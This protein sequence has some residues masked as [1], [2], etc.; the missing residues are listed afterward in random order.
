[1]D[2]QFY[3]LS[4]LCLVAG[5][6]L[7]SVARVHAAVTVAPIAQD[8]SA[9]P[10]VSSTLASPTQPVDVVVLLDDS[11]SMATCWPWPP[12]GGTPFQP[13]CGGV[14]KNPPSDPSELRYSAAR[15]LVELADD[16]DRIAVVRF[17][18]EA[19][20]NTSCMPVRNNCGYPSSLLKTPF[21]PWSSVKQKKPWR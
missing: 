13:P 4:C 19:H 7:T 18:S 17:D 6:L 21:S 15:L 1:M 9:T 10:V 11:G 3:R 2:K 8:A 16:T 12:N 14:S 20:A 5:L